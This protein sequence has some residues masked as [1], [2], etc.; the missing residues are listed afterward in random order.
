MMK[1][2][3][4]AGVCGMIVGVVAAQNP[5]D[6]WH[7]GIGNA[8]C[9]TSG[10]ATQVAGSAQ[11]TFE[12]CASISDANGNLLFYTNGGGR[13]P[14]A[15]G[16]SS[17]KIWNSGSQV[18]YDMGNTEGGGFSAAQSAVF[19]PRPGV[20]NR[21]YLFTMEEIEFNVGGAVLGQPEGRGFGWFEL[22]ALT[23]TVV[24]KQMMV[25]V[26]SYEGLCAVGHDNGVDTWIIIAD[27]NS[28]GLIVY[29]VTA[30]G[31]QEKGRYAHALG[32]N[33]I[34]GSTR[35]D[36]LAIDGGNSLKLFPFNA[37]SGVVG[38][39]LSLPS[40]GG[41]YEFSPCGEFLYTAEQ[42][43]AGFIKY[44]RYTLSA[45]D[46]AATKAS[47]GQD[48]LSLLSGQMQV[49]PDGNI[50]HVT[51]RTGSTVL[52]RI[53]QPDAPNPVITAPFS[54]PRDGSGSSSGDFFG[55]PNFNNRL[56]Q[57]KNLPLIIDA[58][59]PSVAL[60]AD[61][62]VQL[63]VSGTAGVSYLWSTGST[64]SQ[65]QVSQPGTY[66]VTGTDVCGN[67]ATD[68]V[69]VLAG[70]QPEVTVSQ[71]P[72]LGKALISISAPGAG[73]TYRWDD[74]STAATREVYQSGTYAVTVTSADGCTGV[75]SADLLLTP[76]LFFV[77]QGDTSVRAGQVVRLWTV[78]DS[79]TFS[80]SLV[81]EWAPNSGLLS[82]Y[83][84]PAPEA[85]VDDSITYTVIA[86]TP[87]GCSRAETITIRVFDF[88]IQAPN[89]FTPNN[90]QVNDAF[91]LIGGRGDEKVRLFEV[92]D[93]WGALVH[94]TQDVILSAAG[95]G[96]NGFNLNGYD[97][98]SD[99]YVWVAEVVRKDGEV[100][101]LRG[102]V[103]LLR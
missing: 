73:D 7:F 35:G 95:G 16:Q 27:I 54:Y 42:S 48:I 99:V 44:F 71:V 49:A 25:Q 77:A 41:A 76:A 64:E 79:S 1:K 97:A 29:S 101:N 84:C 69:V 94:R 82:C 39:P 43:P 10:T 19:V 103:T 89:A 88:P 93:R 51:H 98:V 75:V 26:P 92:Y 52:N 90:D 70:L 68:S 63:Q 36:F 8:L 96:W 80:G 56:F 9:F 78:A 59:P 87:A 34:K 31:I 83:D 67:Q 85:M 20:A 91:W 5:G 30:A 14:L 40:N 28:A 47:V 62:A 17:G 46:I 66:V 45:P 6:N 72:C 2:M 50:Y 18:I 53:Q 74:N 24:D 81:W 38:L 65:I 32:W 102:Q 33:V 13:D 4:A 60:C 11:Y 86:T 15:G 12:G 57:K 22:D 21:Y 23:G 100:R 3:V 55:L 58:G 37:S 61:T